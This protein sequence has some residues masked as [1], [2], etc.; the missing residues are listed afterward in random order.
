MSIKFC[1][2]ILLALAATFSAVAGA[3]IIELKNGTKLVGT[4]EKEE[5]GRIHIN[6]E[7]L[8]PVVVDAAAVVRTADIPAAAAAVPPSD[9]KQPVPM[10]A[11]APAAATR[12][13]TDPTKPV[14]RRSLSLNGSYNTATYE[15][16]AISG[17]PAGFPT[18]AQAGLQ[19]KLSSLQVAASILRATPTEA[20]TLTGNYGYAS[21]EP[22][23]AVLDNW[24]GEFTYLHMLA[25]KRYVLARSTYKVD[26]ITRVDHSFEQILGYG[27]KLVDT[28]PT[29]LDLI[30][31]VSEVHERKGSKFDDDWIFSVGF[32]ERLEHAFN[33]RVSLEQRFKYRVGVNDTEVWAINSYL[34]LTSALTSKMS[35]TIGATYTYDNTLGPL[36][37]TLASSLLARGLPPSLVAGLHPAKKDQLQLTSGVEFKW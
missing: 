6:A 5:G 28:T 21:Y 20:Y 15:Q 36:P 9:V 4:I 30:P 27:F 12:P 17:A 31:G 35:L 16:G 34:G 24:S 1:G 33:E 7:L 3:Q 19:G 22:T 13:K 18:G 26:K 2:L 25:P 11:A 29:K 14:W 32:L 37:L 23:G 8:G 10:V